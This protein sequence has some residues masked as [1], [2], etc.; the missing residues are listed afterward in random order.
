MQSDF[1]LNR[2]P[3]L[4]R[5][6]RGSRIRCA[7]C[8]RASGIYRVRERCSRRHGTSLLPFFANTIMPN[9]HLIATDITTLAVDAVVSAANRTL[10]SAGGVGGA[11]HRA[12]GPKLREFC[13]TRGSI[14]YGECVMTP[15]FDLPA[16]FVIHAAGPV[17]RGG[18][19]EEEEHLASC[20]RRA[21]DLAREANLASVAFPCISTG[22][23]A[24]PNELAA[25][26]AVETVRVHPFAGDVWFV[27]AREIDLRAYEVA[28]P[29]DLP[30]SVESLH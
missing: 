18:D 29:K 15:G 6:G 24:F 14:A 3:N 21:L 19:W 4:T 23:Y 9:L 12:A 16:R 27:V 26:I 20:Y 11:I 2:A 30:F 10:L 22:A 28:W 1:V 25:R 7:L 5:S 8:L 13:E 17:W